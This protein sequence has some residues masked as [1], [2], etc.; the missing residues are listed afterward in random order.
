MENNETT[1]SESRVWHPMEYAHVFLWLVKDMCWAQGWK[2]AGSLMVAPTILVAIGIT[3]LQRKQPITLVHNIAISIWISSN[4]L[5][6][7]AEFYQKEDLLKPVSTAGFA[8][9]LLLLAVQYVKTLVFP[10][11]KAP[12]QQRP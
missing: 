2:L 6:M 5:W 10:N 3:W 9:G 12:D 11:K 1:S 4:S 8:L 7:L